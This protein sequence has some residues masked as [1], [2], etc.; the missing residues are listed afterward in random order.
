MRDLERVINHLKRDYKDSFRGIIEIPSQEARTSS[1]PR[2]LDKKLQ[3]ILEKS[4][5]TS[6]YSHQL[7]AF[8]SIS[9]GKDTLLLTRTASGKT[10]SFLLPILNDYKRSD[11]KFTTLLMYPTKALSRDQES[12]LGKLLNES[13]PSKFGTYDGDTSAG[14]RESLLKHADFIISN[15]DMLHSGILPNHNR[16]WKNFLSRLKYIVVDEVHTYRGAFGSHVSNVFRR[17]LRVCNLHGSSPIFI[18]SS[19]TIGNPDEHAK[20]LFHKNF[21]VIQDDGSPVRNKKIFFMNPPIVVTEST[22]T[23]R[24]GPAS[25]TIPLLRYSARENIRTICFCRA[26]QEVERLYNAVTEGNTELCQKIKPYRGGLLPNERRKLEKDLFSGKINTI[27]TTNALELGIDIG[28]MSLCIMSGHPGTLSSFWQQAGRV[29]RGE[30]E[31]VIV[32]VAKDTPID[33]Y[34]IHH[35]DFITN[36]PSEEAWLSADNPYILLQHIP[37]AAYELPLSPKENYFESEVYSHALT[38]LK[39]DS[40]LKPYKEFLRY[41]IDDYPAKGVNLRGLTDHNIQIIENG[42]VIGETDPIGAM[43]SLYKSAI[44]QHLGTKYMSVDLDLEKKICN[45]ER[46]DVDYYTEAVWE[47]MV[48]MIETEETNYLSNANLI[49]GYIKVTREPKLFKKIKERTHENIGYGPITL[50]PFTYETTGFSISLAENWVLQIQNIDKRYID[51]AIYSLSYILK[52]TSPSIC[53]GDR[54]DI[55]TDV[56]LTESEEKW[57]SCLYLYD[58]IEGGIGYSEKIFNRIRDALSL[59]LQIIEECECI[60]GCP[61][62]VPPLPPG[63]KSQD[64]E[65]LL[66]ESNG[67]VECAKSLLKYYLNEKFYTPIIKTF[68]LNKDKPPIIKEDPEIV[69]LQ[70]R[71]KRSAEILKKKREKKY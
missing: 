34:I 54:G 1:F 25:I 71:L 51:V 3:D 36:T 67:A 30:K 6:L 9:S 58:A 65:E 59:A 63:I 49:Y 16:R 47:T 21:N 64:I 26:R 33:Q 57:N 29:G 48:D 35:N 15:P 41:A 32:F 43:G 39:E 28:D 4:N 62:C 46:V 66:Y 50:L 20:A 68:T 53:M 27:I 5:I 69:K 37:C 55:H 40:T 8:N 44:Y 7:L 61:S 2:E 60:A 18:C 14:E 24:K 23:Y 10:L 38:A 11:K 12:T 17:L 19:A 22:A 70:N 56:A 31:S 52:N 45:V 42:I 13:L